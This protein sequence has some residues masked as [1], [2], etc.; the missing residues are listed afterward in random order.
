MSVSLT[1]PSR[2][3]S[4]RGMSFGSRALSVSRLVSLSL[5]AGSSA[6]YLSLRLSVPSPLTALAD[7]RSCHQPL[8]RDLS[9]GRLPAPAPDS[10]ALSLPYRAGAHDRERARA[11]RVPRLAWESARRYLPFERVRC[12]TCAR[13]MHPALHLLLPAALGL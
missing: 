11:L 8:S 12:E 6:L 9:L 3:E 7:S 2:L 10:L 1:L 4:G 13:C 5:L